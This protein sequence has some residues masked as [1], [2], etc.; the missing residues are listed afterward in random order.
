MAAALVA[1]SPLAHRMAQGLPTCQF[2]SQVGLPCPTCGT[3]RAAL[4]LSE[5]ELGEALVAYPL[6]TLGWIA[7]VGGGLVAGTMALLGRGLPSDAG[8][9]FPIWLR[10][11]IVAAIL[12]NWA[13]LIATGA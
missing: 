10:V 1:L 11:A 12:A 4:H 8:L 7:L 3:T 2:K 6:A 13:Y 5:F 9:R